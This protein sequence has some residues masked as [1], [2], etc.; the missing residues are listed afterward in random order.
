M[1]ANQRLVVALPIAGLAILALYQVTI[2]SGARQ[3]ERN[4]PLSDSRYVLGD[5]IDT[6]ARSMMS[7]GPPP[8]GIP[9]ID[10]PVFTNP[11]EADLRPD[12]LVIGFAHGGEARAY[13]QKIMVYHEIANDRIGDL[14]VAITYCPLTATAQAF[15]RGNTTLGV[16]GQLLNSNLVMYDRESK[17]YFSQIAATGLTK[18]HRGKTLEEMNLIWTTWKRW[19]SVHPNTRVLSQRTGSLRNYGRDPYGSYNPTGGYYAQAGTIFPVMHQSSR[20]REKEMVVGARTADRSAYFVMADLKRDRVRTTSNFLAVYDPELDTGYIYIT[21]GKPIKVVPGAAGT[22]EFEGASY[23]A[24]T[25]P[26][27]AAI[28]IEAFFFAWNAFYP[29]SEFPGSR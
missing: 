4:L 21:D 19:R 2:S 1:S 13:P 18:Q 6:Y 5:N 17:S 28:P 7:G 29:R 23:A 12:D 15:R 8:D 9:S 25:L 16:S 22:Y 20:H 26:L 27:P 11:D 24:G 3:S 14:N 10:K